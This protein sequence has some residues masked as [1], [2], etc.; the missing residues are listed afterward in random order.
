M[1]NLIADLCQVFVAIG[2]AGGRG[3]WKTEGLKEVL[4]IVKVIAQN[5]LGATNSIIRGHEGR[6]GV[7]R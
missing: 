6:H 4:G 2:T 1:E 7:C 3:A 5:R